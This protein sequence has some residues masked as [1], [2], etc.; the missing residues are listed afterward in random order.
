MGSAL[1]S[2]SKIEVVV[3]IDDEM[4]NEAIWKLAEESM[5]SGRPLAVTIRSTNPYNTYKNGLVTITGVVVDIHEGWFQI[6]IEQFYPKYVLD[7]R[8]ANA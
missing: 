3:V 7:I 5:E 4:L 6:G 1:Y 2:F 8:W